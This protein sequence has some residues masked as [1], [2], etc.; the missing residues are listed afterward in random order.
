MLHQVSSTRQKSWFKK[1][2]EYVHV[3]FLFFPLV[4]RAFHRLSFPRYRLQKQWTRLS[5]RTTLLHTR[6][7]WSPDLCETCLSFLP[8]TSRLCIPPENVER[9][10]RPCPK[11]GRRWQ[12]D[13]SLQGMNCPS[14]EY[15]QGWSL[16]FLSVNAWKSKYKPKWKYVCL[17]S[18]YHGCDFEGVC[19][20][21][22]NS[23]MDP[24]VRDCVR[25]YTEDWAIVNRKWVP[26]W[27]VSTGWHI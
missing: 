1:K 24:H 19:F 22:F 3:I 2:V 10:C 4:L 7:Q 15:L 18:H 26:L 21:S 20:Y 11:R 13:T 17:R 12:G 5:W 27:D 8:M 9:L 16:E 14:F 23:E 6:S 25:S